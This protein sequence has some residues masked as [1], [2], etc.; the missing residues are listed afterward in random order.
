MKAGESSRDSS[1]SAGIGENACGV[2]E[3]SRI[4]SD[5]CFTKLIKTYKIQHFKNSHTKIKIYYNMS[6]IITN[7]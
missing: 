6:C 7:T 3:G 2:I 5:C 1:R 4:P